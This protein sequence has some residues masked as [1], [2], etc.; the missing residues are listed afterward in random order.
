[1]APSPSP[2][3]APYAPVEA[4]EV[5][6]LLDLAESTIATALAGDRP[7]VPT[8][9]ELPAGL[10]A[11]QG[12]FVT[13]TVAGRLNGCIGAIDGDEPLGH[14]VPRLA[15]SAAFADPRLPPLRP[16]DQSRLTIE[17]S[18]LSE[19]M[20]MGVDSRAEL[21]ATLRPGHDGM[22]VAAGERRGLFLPAVWEQIPDPEDFV[23]H[24]WLKAGMRPRTWPPGIQTLR[25][26][27]QRHTRR[28]DPARPRTA[29]RM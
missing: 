12:A 16:A 13:L 20:P 24:L 22:I 28:F 1:M 26:S 17:L 29:A 2:E 11:A 7:V 23:D 9:D 6:L 19:P 8:L 3:T 5:E 21:L 15:L 27:T 10:R 4:T 14:A 18:M 25:F